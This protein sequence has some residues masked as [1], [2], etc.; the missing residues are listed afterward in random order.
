MM[1]FSLAF[2]L[3]RANVDG[4][5]IVQFFIRFYFFLLV[6]CDGRP[7]AMTN[8]N[9]IIQCE[10]ENMENDKENERRKKTKSH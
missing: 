4:N 8:A 7:G 9:Q 3:T 10:E 6:H 5:Q 1:V 2:C